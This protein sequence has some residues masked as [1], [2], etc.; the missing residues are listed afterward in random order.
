MLNFNFEKG[1]FMF[2]TKVYEKSTDHTPV[3]T[4]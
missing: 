2:F 3:R 4:Q 1:K